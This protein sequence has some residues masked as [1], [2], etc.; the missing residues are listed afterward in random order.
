MLAD[1]AGLVQDVEVVVHLPA[2]NVPFTHVVRLITRV[3]SHAPRSGIS[4][5]HWTPQ[6][7]NTT[8]C[9]VGARPVN[10]HAR[11]GEH[12]GSRSAKARTTCH[13]A[14]GRSM[15]GVWTCVQPNCGTAKRLNWS[16]LMKRRFGRRRRSSAGAAQAADKPPDTAP[17]MVAAAPPTAVVFRNVR[18]ETWPL[19]KSGPDT[20]WASF[21]RGARWAR[22]GRRRVSAHGD[23]PLFPSSSGYS[24]AVIFTSSFRWCWP[25]E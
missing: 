10:Q 16:T 15:L 7:L 5:A 8:A 23:R 11:E 17:S 21:V 24:G 25:G 2:G 18:R 1:R 19:E 3:G 12:N 20:A 22:A 13:A 6:S 14:P 4:G 9:S